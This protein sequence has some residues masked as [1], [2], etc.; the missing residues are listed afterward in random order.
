[1]IAHLLSVIFLNFF[2]SL[3]IASRILL[4]SLSILFTLNTL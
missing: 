3:M 4:H 1:M 2:L